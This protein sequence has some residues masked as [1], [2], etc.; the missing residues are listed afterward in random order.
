MEII[1]TQLLTPHQFEQIERLWNEAYPISLQNRFAKLLEGV[2]NYQHYLIEDDH[3]HVIAWAVYFEKDA[4]IRFSI[5]VEEKEQGK[6][7][8]KLLVDKLKDSLGEFYGWVIDHDQDKKQS[9]AF[10]KSPLSFYVKQG[11][12][13]LHEERMD[14]EFLKAVKIKRN[15]SRKG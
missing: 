2:E 15:L 1:T 4:E 14:N 13:I 6:G 10:Y 3:N 9:G 11:F 8:G 7:I 5:I 12:E